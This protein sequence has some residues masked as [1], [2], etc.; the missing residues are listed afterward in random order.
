MPAQSSYPFIAVGFLI[1][2]LGFP[3]LAWAQVPLGTT[4]DPATWIGGT[5]TNQWNNQNNWVLP[6]GGHAVPLLIANFTN[7]ATPGNRIVRDQNSQSIGMLN[8]TAPN[9]LLSLENGTVLTVHGTGFVVNDPAD[10]PI[11]S[12]GT[13]GSGTIKFTNASTGSLAKFAIAPNGTLDLSGRS[14]P[15]GMTAGAIENAGRIIITNRDAGSVGN[16]LT[17]FGPYTGN[18]GSISLRTVLQDDSSPSDQLVINGGRATL[19]GAAQ[20]TGRTLL[21][22]AAGPNST[23]G[24]TDNGI[25]VIDAT[26]GGTTA[27]G[28]FSLANEVRGG[29]FDYRLF[30]GGLDG[31]NPDDWFLRSDFLGGGGNGNGNNGGN[32]PVTPPDELPP[33]ELP[34]VLP[35][36]LPPGVYP[37]IGPEI[38]TYSAV[39]P[40][41]RQLGLATLGTLHERI[42]DTLV[43]GNGAGAG[44]GQIH[45]AWGRLFGEYINDRLRSF[46]H[47]RTDGPLGGFQV[48]VDLLHNG[49]AAGH[50]DVAGIYFALGHANVDVTG[51][52]TNDAATNYELRKTGSIDL[53]GL[54]GGAYWTHYGPSGWYVDAVLQATAYDG[55]A[56]TRY[57]SLSTEG[58]GFA[59]SLEAGYPIP[60]PTLGSGFVLEPQAQIVWQ[61]V[62]FDVDD[63]GLGEVALG[64]T[65]GASGR[66]GL[67]GRWTITGDGGQVWHPYVR[68]N[69]WHNW[70]AQAT[71]TYSG[72]DRVPLLQTGTRVDLSAG[73]TAAVNPGLSL[74]VQAGYQFAV[75]NS[76]SHDHDGVRGSLGRR[77][78][79]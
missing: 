36:V 14:T 71:T 46:A 60:I 24:Y 3:T 22:V 77:Y 41:A 76:G 28:A 66:I 72:I 9:Y 40:K 4:L 50:R 23:G 17:V 10:R 79:W 30:R 56:S 6:S 67:R 29:A 16:T 32:G 18:G 51:L 44:F 58:V 42:G 52:V 1:A 27:A 48:G 8:F 12:V 7:L 70:D 43:I 25:L 39:Q 62:S 11:V 73:V 75:G 55:T 5:G 2:S 78:R 57:A 63:D 34:E 47:P 20:A 31:S 54:S 21:Y 26:N 74:Y 65:S 59:A 45:S 53:N 49:S 61:H 37:I 13:I 38:A 64:S 33:D 19:D 68:A 35:P 69:L 15:D